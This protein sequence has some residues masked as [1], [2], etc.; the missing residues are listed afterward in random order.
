MQ[1][2]LY[3]GSA[4]Y[5]GVFDNSEWTSSSYLVTS[6]NGSRSVGLCICVCVC[7]CVCVC[8]VSVLTAFSSHLDTCLGAWQTSSLMSLSD[9]SAAFLEAGRQV[10][11]LAEKHATDATAFAIGSDSFFQFINANGPMALYQV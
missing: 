1:Q 6:F 5:G 7:V 11:F 3:L 4:G 9:L 2:T 8:I 10:A